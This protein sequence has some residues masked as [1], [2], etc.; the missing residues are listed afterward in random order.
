MNKD[1]RNN[2]KLLGT[3]NNADE[4]GIIANA[5]QIYD[6]NEN[7][8]TQDVSKEHTERIK[9]LETKENS[10][11][12]TLENITKTGEASAASNVTYNHSDSNLNATN[13]QQ[14]IDEISN[15]SYFAKKGGIINVSTNYNST[16]IAEVLTLKQAIAKVPSSNRVLGFTM[17]FLS[18]DG[19]K[20]YQ[21]TGT[22]INTWNDTNNWIRI[23]DNKQLD[24]AT[25]S[26]NDKVDGI[27]SNIRQYYAGVQESLE[28]A[29]ASVPQSYQVG[30][31]VLTFDK[32]GKSLSY[33]LTTSDWS[34][35]L[36]NWDINQGTV[37][38]ND[39]TTNI[40]GDV[41]NN[42]D[43][44]DLVSVDDK[45]QFADHGYMPNN[46]DGMG[47]IYLRK[48]VKNE[49]VKTE[50]DVTSTSTLVSGKY[51]DFSGGVGKICSIQN[52]WS[53]SSLIINNIKNGDQFT[54]SGDYTSN[55]GKYFWAVL[56][57]SN[58]ILACGGITDVDIQETLSEVVMIDTSETPSM[59][60]M[61]FISYN[62]PPY[63]AIKVSKSSNTIAM[64]MLDQNIFNN[65]KTV[66]IIRYDYDLNLGS[67]ILPKD[68]VLW[69]QGGS[70]K[71]GNI[72][73]KN[74]RIIAEPDDNI[75]GREINIS[76][77]WKNINWY[78]AWFGASADGETDDTKVLQKCLDLGEALRHK[79][80]IIMYGKTYRTTKG[81]FLKGSTYL[82]GGTLDAKFENPLDWVL[83]TYALYD[84]KTVIGY[85]NAAAWSDFDAG[86]IRQTFGSY[87]EDL[88]INGNLNLNSDGTYAPI[89]GGLRIQASNTP[90]NRVTINNVGVGICRASS[91]TTSDKNMNI[92]AYFKAYFGWCVNGVT[93]YDS[94]LN[95]HARTYKASESDTSVVIPFALE[96]QDMLTSGDPYIDGTGGISDTDNTKT[97]PLFCSIKVGYAFNMT[98]INPVVDY[99]NE[100]SIVAWNDSKITIVSP[101]WEGVSKCQI[102]T[103]NADV[104]CISP[105]IVGEA[106]Y[107]IRMIYRS[108]INLIA[109]ENLNCSG[110]GIKNATTKNLYT[111][112][113]NS[114]LH[115][116]VMNEFSQSYPFSDIFR[117]LGGNT[118]KQLGTYID[119]NKYDKDKGQKIINDNLF[120]SRVST[121]KIPSYMIGRID[122]GHAMTFN[123]NI[124]ITG[125]SKS[126]SMLVI[127]NLRGSVKPYNK[128]AFEDLY[129]IVRSMDI[130]NSFCND[131]TFINCIIYIESNNLRDNSLNNMTF[132]NCHIIS[133]N[134]NSDSLFT[135]NIYLDNTTFSL[136]CRY[137]HPHNS[138]NFL[139][140]KTNK[141]KGTTAE[142]NT[143]SFDNY[144]GLNFYNIDI[145]RN[146]V[147]NGRQ[148]VLMDGY[149]YIPTRGITDQLP[150]LP[151]MKEGSI[152]YDTTQNKKYELTTNGKCA[153][154]EFRIDFKGFPKLS[155]TLYIG[156]TAVPVVDG[157]F[158]VNLP[159]GSYPVS[160]EG[161][162][163]C[164]GE[165]NQVITMLTISKAA[166]ISISL[167]KSFWSRK[168]TQYIIPVD[169]NGNFV[170]GLTLMAGPYKATED[171]NRKR[172]TVSVPNGN[173]KVMA[174]GYTEM[175]DLIVDGDTQTL[176]NITFTT[177]IG[178]ETFAITG[179]EYNKDAIISANDHVV[180]DGTIKIT[181]GDASINVPV[182]A[183][184]IKEQIPINGSIFSVIR[185]SLAYM[186]LREWFKAGHY[187][188]YQYN[189]LGVKLY[190]DNT[191]IGDN[192]TAT[193]N[194]GTT[195]LTAN[196]IIKTKGTPA[197][198][199]EIQ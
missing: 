13:V 183:N 170:S 135:G 149:P 192:L 184:D 139:D 194:S 151:N 68:S 125:Y 114:N 75:F 14:A 96:Y 17:T 46:I 130:F 80:N 79:V 31:L 191:I 59:L 85:R 165:G 180:T 61:N 178:T 35:I 145:D 67:L 109:A 173:Y 136:H 148:W 48:N 99:Y 122:Q 169:A 132:S 58:K 161:Y 188:E 72:R 45:L 155:Q 71:R 26:I 92:N 123:T 97:R 111:R 64:N 124:R 167:K 153:C 166:N 154:A 115:I 53:M 100:V 107:D 113:N 141:K 38:N 60:V 126:T 25:K 66:Y 70:I 190:T 147:W 73:G 10:M 5:N 20:T 95:S 195:N 108:T 129:I 193:W 50:E 150:Q 16:N 176:N 32:D 18:S 54:L 4:S 101:W 103:N 34:T 89:Y 110:Y 127:E 69:F 140:I 52:R 76:G 44:E 133:M 175:F 131:V 39:N 23:V 156:T 162:D 174:V 33:K 21:F 119:K 196:S 86:H 22:S 74:T 11:Q 105:T 28:N 9:I 36:D 104:T 152:F 128:V 189:P 42:P 185:N 19:W 172:Y 37:I 199:T 182:K 55:Y 91:L 137:G 83:Q 116:N 57:S 88:T 138:S 144:K 158:S 117:F 186:I 87:I 65:Q 15:I 51:Y 81:L 168:T 77:T 197:I 8:S 102:A 84:G 164:I 112:G 98:F 142:R 82:Y 157:E 198:W 3:L 121:I 7:K 171:T 90:T 120:D 2:I 47:K 6:A 181:V 27:E 29:I 24:N 143:L 62:N 30:G 160:C 118:D 187:G 40:S 43:G 134:R 94:Y 1:K 12:T 93:V 177:E 78:P 63:S 163:V 49:A 179:T 106:E 41:I 159:S 56:N 146:E